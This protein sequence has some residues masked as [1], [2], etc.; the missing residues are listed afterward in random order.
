MCRC[1]SCE[2]M[3]YL[4]LSRMEG[5]IFSYKSISQLFCLSRFS[6]IF[7]I[8]CVLLCVR[9]SIS[10]SVNNFLCYINNMI[11]CEWKNQ[12]YLIHN[13]LLQ[14][15]LRFLCRH[16]FFDLITWYHISILVSFANIWA[17]ILNI[18]I[19]LLY[20]AD[21]LCICCQQCLRRQRSNVQW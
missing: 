16:L 7:M 8:M 10:I 1:T 14:R 21:Y 3:S 12:V 15:F 4:L 18:S 6:N 2:S 13:I 19:N 9:R 5:A 17:K 20:Q 11:D